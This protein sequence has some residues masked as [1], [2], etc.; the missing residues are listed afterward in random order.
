MAIA[1]NYSGL[2]GH[3]ILLTRLRLKKHKKSAQKLATGYVNSKNCLFGELNRNGEWVF[4]D[5]AVELQKV[6][7]RLLLEFL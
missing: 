5:N 3:Y 1:Q 4:S 7:N 6:V 2:A